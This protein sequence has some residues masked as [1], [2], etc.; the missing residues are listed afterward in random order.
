MDEGT[1][2]TTDPAVSE[3]DG[4]RLVSNA[5]EERIHALAQGQNGN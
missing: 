4:A 5:N 3:A 2:R 1:G